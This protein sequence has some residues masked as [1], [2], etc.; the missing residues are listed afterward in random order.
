VSTDRWDF[1]AQTDTPAPLATEIRRQMLLT[2]LEDCFRLRA[3]RET[4]ARPIYELTMV[5]RGPNLH[6][7]T[8]LEARGPVIKNGP[9]S[10]QLNNSSMEEF[11]QRLSLHLGRRVL[12]RTGM[13]G[14]FSLSLDWM[15]EPGEDGGAD[16][17]GLPPGTPMPTGKTNGPSIFEAIQ[18]QLALRLSPKQ[19]PVEM[20][21]I[22]SARRPQ[23]H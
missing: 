5:S 6:E 10:I 15:P 7:D 11:A 4:K 2:L 13:S 3:H 9:G 18:L 16:A 22:D 17:A 8:G 1:E 23:A 21:V 19:G 20:I 12:D 14:I